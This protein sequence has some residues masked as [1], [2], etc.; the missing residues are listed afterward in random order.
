MHLSHN[1]Q[2][3]SRHDWY[4]NFELSIERDRGY[5]FSQDLY[6]PGPISATLNRGDDNGLIFAAST[7]IR[8][9]RD[10]DAAFSSAAARDEDHLAG[11]PDADPLV[12]S[13]TRATNDFIVRRDDLNTVID[14]YPWFEDWGRDTFIS[15]PG[16]CLVPGRFDMAR[17]I[18][19]AFAAH[20]DQG[21]IP[22]RFP[23]YGEP[24]VYNTVDGTLW[25]VNAIDRYL[26]YT[27][28]WAFIEK[29]IYPVLVN[30]IECHERGT[31]HGIKQADDGLLFSGD[32]DHA[33]TWM[34]ARVGDR[35]I[36]PRIGKAV[37]VCALWYN[38]LRIVSGY[39]E[40]M[41][42]RDRAKRW[43]AT[44][45]LAHASFNHRF[46]RAD[47]CCLYDVIEV[48]GHQGSVDKSVRPNQLLAISLTHPVL[49]ESRRRSVVAICERDLW[50][51]L[52]VRT[53]APNDPAYCPR[54]Q[55]AVEARDAAYHQGTVWPWLLGPFVT[56]YIRAFDGLDTAR[57]K[58]RH[59]LDGLLLHLEE[60]GIGSISEV[61]DAQSPHTPGGCPWQAWSVAE[62][63]RALCEDILA[64][65][66]NATKQRSTPQP[67]NSGT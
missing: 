23:P 6:M 10:Y 9:W 29:E 55:G 62:P 14:G 34:D 67:V 22:N 64:T 28:D 17:N 31:R 26:A 40:K 12:G 51:P 11:T 41:K 27:G 24:P 60:A 56:A 36:T 20:V 3:R 1:G 37:E 19:R 59:F 52:G 32:T 45:D 66:P 38:A 65:H 42:D 43:R 54:Y 5:D 2:F 8:S 25:Y 13:L 49:E 44:A 15:L 18:I 57:I 63:L 39:A 46:W 4:Y 50:T 16:L 47:L 58:A 30:I 7:Q 21:M 53:L 61:A 35:S 48:D 33:L